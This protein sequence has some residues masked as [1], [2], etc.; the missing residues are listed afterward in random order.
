MYGE[1]THLQVQC[2]GWAVVVCAGVV[3]LLWW[4]KRFRGRSGIGERSGG[5]GEEEGWTVEESESA[6]L[7]E[8]IA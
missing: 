3:V 2:A 1:E 7:P 6:R 4:G 5:G 8:G